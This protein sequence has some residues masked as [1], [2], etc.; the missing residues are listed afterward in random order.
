MTCE[1]FFHKGILLVED[2]T[3][4]FMFKLEQLSLHPVSKN[5]FWK[6]KISL[7]PGILKLRYQN[8]KSMLHQSTS[9]QAKT[10]VVH[11]T[12]YLEFLAGRFIKHGQ[13]LEKVTKFR[14]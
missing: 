2:I 11:C 4:A 1:P 13:R 5:S 3:N 7:T 6:H 14:H 8:L 12:A 10:S 9:M